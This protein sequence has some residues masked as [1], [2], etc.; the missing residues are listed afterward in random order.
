M[1]ERKSVFD[2]LRDRGSEVFAQVSAELMQSPHFAKALEGAMRGKQKLDQAVGR[3]L[4]N[5]N[6]PTRSE[7]KRA[8]GRIEAL[9]RELEAVKGKRPPRARRASRRPA[10]PKAAS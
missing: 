2:T 4:K 5:M 8:L 3:V 10:K 1:S 9:E 6:I 7:F